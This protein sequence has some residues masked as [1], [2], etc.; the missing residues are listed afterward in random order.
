M[1]IGIGFLGAGAHARHHMKELQRLIGV[2]LISVYDVDG[3]RSAQ[4]SRD[5]AP[6]RAAATLDEILTE[7]EVNAVV[8]ATPAETHRELAIAALNSGRDVL[9]EKPMAHTPGDAR[10]ILDAAEANKSAILMV[11]HCERFNP[12]YIDAFKAVHDDRIGLP[13]FASASRISPLHLNNPDWALGVLDTAVHDIDLMLALLGSRPVSVSAQ[14]TTTK[15]NLSIADQVVYQIQFENGALAS[16]HI[17]WL[18]FSG[19]YPL[20]GNAHPRLFLAG[21]D[22]SLSVDLWQ[23]PVAVHTYSTGAYF[24]PDSVLLGYGDYF[25]EVTAQDYAFVRAVAERLPSPVPASDAYSALCVAHAAHV[26]LTELS[27]APV[28]L[29]AT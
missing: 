19:G 8:I 27:G 12:S 10:A 25:T 17:G 7:Q 23:R 13:R 26:S 1:S 11:G 2:R 15:P 29:E 3:L 24:W 28:D 22:G 4:A 21:T 5:F 9:L 20:S 16:G 6:L 18:P 14:G